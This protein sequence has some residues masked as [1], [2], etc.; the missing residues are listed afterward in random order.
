MTTRNQSLDVLR[1]AFAV[2]I[3]GMLIIGLAGLLIGLVILVLAKVHGGGDLFIGVISCTALVALA[4][5]AAIKMS[6]NSI[7]EWKRERKS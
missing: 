6:H 3:G 7:E 5:Y 2:V 4:L 1:S